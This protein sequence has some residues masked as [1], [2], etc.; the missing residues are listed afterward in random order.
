MTK[1]TQKEEFFHPSG[2]QKLKI[3]KGSKMRIPIFTVNGSIN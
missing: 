2:W 3:D 1:S